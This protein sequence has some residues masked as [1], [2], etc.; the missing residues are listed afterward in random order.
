MTDPMYLT[1]RPDRGWTLDWALEHNRDHRDAANQP[2]NHPD[3][4]PPQVLLWHA[5]P[6]IRVRPAPGTPYPVPN[7]LD[8]NEF[9]PPADRFELWALQTAMHTIDDRVVPNGRWN[10]HF[11]RRVK[12]LRAANGLPRPDLARVDAALWQ[13][14]AIQAGFWA[15]PWAPGG[16]T[17]ADLLE[18]IVGMATPRPGDVTTRTVSA[19]SVALPT[20]AARV[21]VAVHRRGLAEATASDVSVL[22]LRLPL[23]TGSAPNPGPPDWAAT[24]APALAGVEAAMEAVGAGGGPLGGAVALPAGWDAPD[25]TTQIRRPTRDIRTADAAVVT[26]EVVFA[27]GTWLLLAIVHHGPGTPDLIGA[28]TLR[29][30]VCGSPHVAA[31][32]VEVV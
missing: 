30:L 12:E 2:A 23:P 19:A 13:L 20:G 7:S 9:S 17:E 22:L 27:V 15:D 32:S 28:A 14:G 5:S 16:P 25:T 11:R 8:W 31:R 26:F 24:A 18:R 1:A 3:G 29:E 21:D 10:L 6:D 4:T